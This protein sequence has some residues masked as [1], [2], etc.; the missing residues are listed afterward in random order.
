MISTKLSIIFIL[1][2]CLDSR[3]SSADGVPALTIARLLMM[4]STDEMAGHLPKEP[5]Y[6]S[7]QAE[8]VGRSLE[9]V[10]GRAVGLVNSINSHAYMSPH[11][12]DKA[13][14]LL[15][16]IHGEMGLTGRS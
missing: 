10:C 1:S 12:A 13:L 14:L 15:T 5:V 4:M 2:G 3:Y 7:G 16:L 11:K 6:E 9:V 8:P